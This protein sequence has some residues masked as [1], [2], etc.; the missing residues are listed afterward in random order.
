MV[1]FPVSG[2]EVNP[3]I[4]LLAAFLVSGLTAPEGVSGAFLLLPFQMSVLGFTSPAVSPTNLVY[5][6]VAT[7]GGV[8]R[9]VKE[10][11]V[12][13]PLARTVVLGTL[14][15]A[16]V[17]AVLRVTVLS[18]P[19]SFEVFVGFVLLYFGARL[20]YGAFAHRRTGERNAAGHSPVRGVETSPLRVEYEYGGKRYAFTP[21]AVFALSLVVGVIGGIYSIGGGSIIAPFLVVMGLPVYTVAGATMLGTFVTSVAGVAFFEVLATTSLGAEA[22]IAPDWLLGAVL[23]VGGAGRDLSRGEV[24]E[25]PTRPLDTSRARSAG[26]PVGTALRPL[27]ANFRESPFSRQLG[28][29]EQGRELP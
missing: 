17:G 8:Y 13:W 7:P 22:P 5:N 29:L 2:V 27:V 23:G 28:E 11:R 10:A 21:A 6:V 14:P 9:Y 19:D 12:V 18:D 1:H 3:L 25:I 20:L 24:A 4:P 16:F 15:S 26:Y